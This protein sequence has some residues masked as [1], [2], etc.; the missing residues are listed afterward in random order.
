[1]AAH[2]PVDLA[3]AAESAART[4]HAHLAS[5]NLAVAQLLTSLLLA[6]QQVG[7]LHLK[8]ES[9]MMRNCLP[10]DQPYIPWKEACSCHTPIMQQMP[11]HRQA[12][13]A[14][15]LLKHLQMCF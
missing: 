7:V 10:G 8:A 6:M 15:L 12:P 3:E 5:L 2:L 14:H 9:S 13:L 1:M 11:V 4:A